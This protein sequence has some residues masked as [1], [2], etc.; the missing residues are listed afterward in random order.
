[1]G[2]V[3]FV[4]SQRTRECGIR[5][6]LGSTPAGVKWLVARQGMWPVLF[7]LIGG[8][9]G[10]LGASHVI[11]I[12]LV[13]IVDANATMLVADVFLLAVAAAIAVY[14]PARRVTNVDPALTLRCD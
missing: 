13:G 11:S 2:I 1:M 4:A 10:T 3:G 6:A 7:G 8:I 12:Y 9:A 5:I 14:L